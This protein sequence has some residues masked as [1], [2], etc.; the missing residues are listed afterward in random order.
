M[1]LSRHPYAEKSG[2]G[3]MLR[4]R[5]EQMRRRFDTRIVVMGRP[6]GDASDAS[7]TFL[8]MA[9]PAAL[10]L[11]AARLAGAPLQTWLYHSARARAEI[12]RMAADAA[13]IYVDMLRLVPLTRDAPP[14]VA[15]VIDYD[16]LLSERYRLAASADYDVMG[17]LA[18]RVGPLRPLA[19]AIAAPLLRIEA[20]RCA[21]YERA[22]LGEA[23]LVLFTSSREAEKMGAPH[24]M[25]APPMMAPLAE[26]PAPG[27]RLIFL[28]NMRYAENVTMLRALAHAARALAG[29]GGWPTDAVI[30]AVGDH[31]PELPAELASPH[32]R[33]VGRIEDL[34][35]L[36]GAGV[37]LAPVIGGSGVK[38]KVLDG[39]ALGCPVAATPK[40]LEGLGARANR[41]VLAAPDPKS[42]LGAALK[43]RDRAVLKRMLASRAR[44]YLERAHA[45]SLGDALC[46]AVEAAIAR[47]QETL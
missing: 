22:I 39:M 17:F 23:D 9:D 18:Q 35:E 20:A 46:D 5:I 14:R 4:Q 8:P 25:A 37:F 36:A 45:P 40:A 33:F 43:L 19:R 42:V 13:A 11:N 26:T 3:F 30:E 38:I 1:L 32:V 15:R 10:A 44:R 21:A 2:R 16:D 12:A 31:P 29:E 34:A 6:A 41:D 24:V 7:L 28:G 27:R 47:R